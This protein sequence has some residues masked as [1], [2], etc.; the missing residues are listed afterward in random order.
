MIRTCLCRGTLEEQDSTEC[1]DTEVSLEADS[2]TL[3]N[4]SSMANWVKSSGLRSCPV[5]LGDNNRRNQKRHR[6]GK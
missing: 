6:V 4:L 5:Q 1:S 2:K 3:T